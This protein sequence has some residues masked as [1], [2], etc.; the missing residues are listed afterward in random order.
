MQTGTV[1][2]PF[3]QRSMTLAL[4]K[5]QLSTADIRAGKSVD[6]WKIYRSACEARQLLGLRD[7]A[8]AVLNALLSFYPEQEL[9]EGSNLV[10]FPSNVQLSIRAN[11]IA[12]TTLR[13]NLALLVQAGLI[14]RNDSPNGKRYARKSHD[15][16]IE[17]AYGF[18]LAPLLAR[19]EELA[20]MAS[21][22]AEENRLVRTAKERITITRRDIRKLITAALEEGASGDWQAIEETLIGAIAR[23][24]GVKNLGELTDYLETLSMLR[25]EVINL[26]E[27]Q[28]I[29]K[30]TDG[31]ADEIRQHI[32][33]SNTYSHTEFEP[34]SE[35]ALGERPVRKSRTTDE[36]I[37]AFPLGMVLRACPQISDYA[38]GGTISN[39]RD[40]MSAA[41]VVR[42]MLGV[43]PSA[44]QGACETMGAENAA[45]AVAC[46]LERANHINSAGGYLR[47]LARRAEKG[48]FSLGP[49]LMALLRARESDDRRTA[50]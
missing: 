5:G 26:L 43:S 3:G 24:K 7:R 30:K 8:L 48:E 34:S 1:T 19:A 41:V 27:M 40:L 14:Q 16:E 15:G 28:L 22:V 33:N 39:W 42:T 36:P 6:K 32:Q 25:E 18:S 37:K 47:D 35:K 46:M 10:V 13:E 44:Y 31:N 11:G 17:T 45:V 12:G 2:T 23:F 20:V 4:V 49:M 50:C 38:V 9:S 29:S 21:Q